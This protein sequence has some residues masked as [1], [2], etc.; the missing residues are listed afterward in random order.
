MG[1]QV[2]HYENRPEGTLVWHEYLHEGLVVAVDSTYHGDGDSVYRAI[3]L[4]VETGTWGRCGGG[5]DS[6][7]IVV[8]APEH[9]RK[10]YQQYVE[11]SQ[12]LASANYSARRIAEDI[13]RDRFESFTPRRG[14]IVRV[15]KGRKIPVGTEATV[16]VRTESQYGG[17]SVKV[18]LENGAEVWTNENNVEVIAEPVRQAA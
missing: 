11:A 4:D 17:F 13:S 14:K 9:L 8:D 16:L 3:Y 7:G 1:V 5:Y 15:V 2:T 6:E 18:A 10:A 12:A